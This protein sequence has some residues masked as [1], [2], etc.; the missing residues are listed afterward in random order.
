[1]APKFGDLSSAKGLKALDD[2]LLTRSYIEGYSASAADSDVFSQVGSAPDQTSYPHAFRWFVHIAAIS[3][4]RGLVKAPSAGPG[5][6]KA[7]AAKGG[8]A[9]KPAP[10]DD[11]DDDLFGDDDEEEEKVDPA[12]AKAA[13]AKALADAKKKKEKAKPVERTQIVV[14]IK[15]WEA[16]CDLTALSEEIKKIQ[17]DGLVWGEGIKLVPVAF[18]IKKLIMS[19]VVEDEKVCADDVTDPIEALEDFVQSVDIATMSKI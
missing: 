16:E 18:G 19:C 4:I 9:K 15:P 13:R 8:K 1:M 7:S 17:K 10:A 11:D 2:Y 6:A 5:P 12:A 14:E 3:G